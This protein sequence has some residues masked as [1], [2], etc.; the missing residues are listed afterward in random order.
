M[1]QVRIRPKSWILVCLW[2][3]SWKWL[4]R[5]SRHL[6]IS[7]NFTLWK[8]LSSRWGKY[9]Q[10]KNSHGGNKIGRHMPHS[11]NQCTSIRG[12]HSP[13]NVTKRANLAYMLSLIEMC[14]S[15]HQDCP[16]S[17]HS[18]STV[19][20]YVFLSDPFVGHLEIVDSI[21]CPLQFPPSQQHTFWC[22]AWSSTKFFN[23]IQLY[24]VRVP[25]WLLLCGSVS[26]LGPGE[27]HQ[28][29]WWQALSLCWQ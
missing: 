12:Y 29:D 7:K 16:R 5:S 6:F 25:R 21:A 1:P 17:L 27:I 8:R 14:S 18:S 28:Q 11:G 15:S 4:K 23:T 24:Q 20:G 26:P 22:M 10:K 13:I 3:V 2:M 19:L 9:L